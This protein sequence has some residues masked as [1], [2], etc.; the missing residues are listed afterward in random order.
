MQGKWKSWWRNHSGKLTSMATD[1]S[2][3]GS[4]SRFWFKLRRKSEWIVQLGNKWMTF[5]MKLMKMETIELTVKSL[6][7]WSRKYSRWC[8]TKIILDLSLIH[9]YAY[10][11]KKSQKLFLKGRK[12]NINKARHQLNS[13]FV[14]DLRCMEFNF[15]SAFKTQHFFDRI[16]LPLKHKMFYRIRS[17]K[18]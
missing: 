13:E 17:L 10:S 5:W 3:V 16:Y 9:A 1:T 18:Y 6:V 4:L 8:T 7:S 12:I 11:L 15:L 2:I 14:F